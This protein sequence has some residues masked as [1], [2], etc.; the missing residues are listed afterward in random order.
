M[1]NVWSD[2]RLFNSCPIL[3]NFNVYVFVSF[4]NFFFFFLLLRLTQKTK[5]KHLGIRLI[6]KAELIIVIYKSEFFSV[7]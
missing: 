4:V 7:F 3:L 6:F 1:E 5:E 2:L